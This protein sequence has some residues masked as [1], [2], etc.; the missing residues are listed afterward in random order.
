MRTTTD[1]HLKLDL[2]NAA[3]LERYIKAYGSNRNRLINEAVRHYLLLLRLHRI[4]NQYQELGCSIDNFRSDH[5][6]YD[7]GQLSWLLK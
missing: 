4:F 1:Y 6:E 3:A 7:F 5:C 2:E